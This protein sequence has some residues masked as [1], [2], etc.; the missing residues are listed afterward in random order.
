LIPLHHTDP[1]LNSLWTQ[2]FSD[3]DRHWTQMVS[4]SEE[5]TIVIHR[6]NFFQVGTLVKEN[7]PEIDSPP[8]NFSV[9]PTSD[10][11]HRYLD[12]LHDSRK[13]LQSKMFHADT[14]FLF[15]L[16]KIQFSGL[17]QEKALDLI[18]GIS[19]QPFG[20]PALS[21]IN[22]SS[23]LNSQVTRGRKNLE[24][25][26]EGM[27]ESLLP[28]I[29][30]ERKEM[31]VQGRHL[32]SGSLNPDLMRKYSQIYVFGELPAKMA[33]AEGVCH[34]QEFLSAEE[35]LESGMKA[36]NLGIGRV[37]YFL[38]ANEVSV[39]GKHV[40]Q[41]L[42]D[43]GLKG[44]MH[45]VDWPPFYDP[46]FLAGFVQ[47]V[48][49]STPS[50]LRF[51][52]FYFHEVIGTM[53]AVKHLDLSHPNWFGDTKP[54]I[55]QKILRDTQESVKEIDQLRAGHHALLISPYNFF[56][57][58]SIV[59]EIYGNAVNDFDVIEQRDL[60]NSLMEFLLQVQS[61][62]P[63]FHLEFAD[64]SILEILRIVSRSKD[65][66]KG[67][68]H[69]KESQWIYFLRLLGILSDH[70]F[71]GPHTVHIDVT[72]KCNTKCTF[73]GYHTP[74]ISDRPWAE[75]G[76]DELS[77]DFELFTHMVEDLQKSHT[78]EDI[79]LTGGGE[80][81]MHPKIMEM[82]EM[83]KSKDMH[84]ILFT[85]GLLLYEK[86]SHQLVDLGVDKIYWSV[87]SASTPT[88][89]IQHPGSNEKT[90]PR[91]VNQMR[92]LLEYRN[93]SAKKD[94]VIV[95]VNVLSGVN[96]HEVLDMVDLAVDLGVDELRFQ[97]MHYGNEQTDHM[98]LTSAQI[99]HLYSLL[100]EIRDRA[101]K[102]GITLL[103]NFEFQLTQ[104]LDFHEKDSDLK[105]CD[106]AY[107]LYNNTG[108]FVGYFFSRTWVD[109]R[110]SFCCHDRVA[111]DLKQGGFKKN[112][113][114]D[115]YENYRYVAKHFDD[116]NNVDMNDGH[117]GG[118]L[119][120]DDCSWCGN[121]EFMNRANL[122]LERTGLKVYLDV[123]LGRLYH[124]KKEDTKDLESSNI[125][126]GTDSFKPREFLDFGGV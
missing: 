126:L 67:E 61:R 74:L 97:I 80:P 118:W 12:Y 94:P 90:F 5:T 29:P 120:A 86:N 40:W 72:S 48:Y 47:G 110:M 93:S 44:S 115:E 2:R 84:I 108:C 37:N 125:L 6:Y 119:L 75:N 65:S 57:V 1:K 107:N 27:K 3:G 13:V 53:I 96:V 73:C 77:V 87:Q 117:K 55:H 25:Y 45:H 15:L 70:A 85:N 88:W 42:K 33:I 100:P 91:V 123:G 52:H 19:G 76:W 14:F 81:L 10:I 54:R 64:S 49:D 24:I 46:P 11:F 113:F 69:A 116:E 30:R 39:R 101:H 59:E 31:L 114:S 20:P 22:Q 104:L 66:F 95:S 106:W 63:S 68:T 83:I 21:L 4:P 16:W 111:G 7:F 26:S 28:E 105:S 102:G 17:S 78:T 60:T 103:E 8:A 43:L 51:L 92:E 82:I 41:A 56:R 23:G 124:D 121:Y 99:R 32:N 36:I 79:L 35:L 62:E 50:T 89:I 34:V 18:S 71:V 38:S 109:G 98:M 112:W 122:T 9:V 58:G